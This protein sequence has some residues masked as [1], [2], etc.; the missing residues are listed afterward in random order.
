MKQE[1]VQSDEGLEDGDGGVEVVQEE[2]DDEHSNINKLGGKA[3]TDPE[4]MHP[5]RALLNERRV[6]YYTEL[7]K[8]T[9]RAGVDAEDD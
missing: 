5:S 6:Q 9:N 8:R 1:T 4:D 2:K 7:V 3:T